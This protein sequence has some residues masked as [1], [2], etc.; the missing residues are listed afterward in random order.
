[1]FLG[2]GNSI[3]WL[4]I[5]LEV[6]S[7]FKMPNSIKI[8]EKITLRVV[9]LSIVRFTILL[10]IFHAR[11]CPTFSKNDANDLMHPLSF[12]DLAFSQILFQ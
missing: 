4:L 3:L 5:F 12:V 8:E 6:N 9:I 1:M 2:M 7:T 11:M 10:E